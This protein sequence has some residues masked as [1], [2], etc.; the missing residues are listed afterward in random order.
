VNDCPNWGPG[1]DS[2]L[3][4]SNRSGRFDLYRRALSSSADELVWQSERDK[5]PTDWSADG[6]WVIF[7]QGG[8]PPS[9]GL[10]IWS[11][12]AESGKADPFL[13]TAFNERDGRLSPDNRWLAYSSD[14]SGTFEVYVRSF[15][16]PGFKRQLSGEGGSQP[17]WRRDGKELF[18]LAADGR[19]MVVA[20]SSRPGEGFAAD[21]PRALFDSRLAASSSDAPLYDATPDGQRFLLSLRQDP[22]ASPSMSVVLNWTSDLGQ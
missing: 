13:A 11:W 21:T 17:V 22:H 12:S 14:E 1:G 20:V 15:P 5:S 10:D 3:F 2:V 16:R 8:V 18:Y 6:R 7:N 4:G 19:L 9:A